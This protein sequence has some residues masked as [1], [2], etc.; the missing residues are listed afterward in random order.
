M[1]HLDDILNSGKLEEYVFGLLDDNENKKIESL[2]RK[3]PK[4]KSH[5]QA[6]EM[7]M[8]GLAKANQIK[9]HPDLKYNISKR[10]FA[11][12]SHT[13]SINSSMYKWISTIGIA[14][15]LFLGYLL[16]QSSNENTEINEK[17]IALED[18]CS[19]K[20]MAF[21]MDGELL[22][23]LRH[24]ATVP[25]QLDNPATQA[26]MLVYFNP[27][28]EQSMIKINRLPTLPDTETYQLWAD[29]EGVMID[30][31]TF[32][33]SNEF[34]PVKFINDPESFNITIEPSGGSDHPTVSRLVASQKV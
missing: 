19:K 29:V 9:P 10:L 27:V 30:M 13:A 31:G 7:S 28:A 26:N 11:N 14:A 5:V 25:V 6:I 3:H 22:Y 33:I 15:S 16:F 2:I 23:F 18:E 1:E 34:I 17:L 21:Q 24:E 8:E 12:G 20:Q 32:K 4:L